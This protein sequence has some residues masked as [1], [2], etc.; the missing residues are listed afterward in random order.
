MLKQ[1]LPIFVCL[2]SSSLMAEP[3]EK[4]KKTYIST[5]Q[6]G[7]VICEQ[8]KECKQIRNECNQ[9]VKTYEG[10]QSFISC[11]DD[12]FKK[13][14]DNQKC[15]YSWSQEQPSGTDMCKNGN[16]P[17]IH[18]IAYACPG[19]DLF[20]DVHPDK[21]YNCQGVQERFDSEQKSC[22]TLQDHIRKFCGEDLPKLDDCEHEKIVLK[23]PQ[24][25]SSLIAVEDVNNEP[26][27][28]VKNIVYEFTQDYLNFDSWRSPSRENATSH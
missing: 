2:L 12:R 14:S 20:G 21:E 18:P 4:M 1:I 7:R 17:S 3:C 16:Y 9:N 13:A 22:N 15:H 5:C 10:C 23:T 11:I 8:I 6:Q 19:F 28:E 27:K 26:R 25:A 24:E